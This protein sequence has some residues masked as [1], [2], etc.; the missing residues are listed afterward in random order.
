MNLTKQ[1]AIAIF[2]TGA[3]LG[4]ALGITKG[5]ISQWPE[6]LDQKQTAMVIGA[7]VQ[8]G[9]AVPRGFIRTAHAVQ[10]VAA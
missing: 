9:R 6:E 7:A 4:R 8:S 5:A 10:Q 3:E 2:G 1:Q